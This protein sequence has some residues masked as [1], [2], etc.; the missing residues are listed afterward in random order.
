MRKHVAEDEIPLPVYSVWFH[1]LEAGADI[2]PHREI[3]QAITAAEKKKGDKL[4][5]LPGGESEAAR[6]WALKLQESVPGGELN[7]LHRSC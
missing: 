3:H 6:V 1:V 5:F 7:A 4:F 2:S